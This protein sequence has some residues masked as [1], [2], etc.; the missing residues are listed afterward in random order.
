M[1][2]EKAQRK[3]SEL[4]S[5]LRQRE[6]IELKIADILNPERV[7]ALPSNFTLN[8]EVLTVVKEA[9]GK[10]ISKLDILH[11]L[12]K[13]YPSYG[14]DRKRVASSL[15]YLKNG[16]KEVEIIGRATYKYLEKTP[17]PTS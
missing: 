10:G 1:L 2:D 14:I 4:Q 8:D 13:K 11:M 15:A 9:G 16:K 12:Q 17:S 3:L 5:L 7:V 6:E